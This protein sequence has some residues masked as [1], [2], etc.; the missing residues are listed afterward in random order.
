MATI[1]DSRPSFDHVEFTIEPFVKN[2]LQ[3]K[4]DTDSQLCLPHLQ[5]PPCPRGSLCPLRHANPSPLNFKPVPPIPTTAHGRTVCKHWLRGL[6]KKGNTCEFMHEYNLRKMPECW[7]FAKYGFCSNGDECMYLHVTESMRIRECPSYRKGFCRL[8]PECP[9]KH[10]RKTMCPDYLVGF[11]E[12]GP[13]CP[14]G[15]PKFDPDPDPPSSSTRIPDVSGARFLPEATFRLNRPDWLAF[16]ADTRSGTGGAGGAGGG[17][18]GW[19]DRSGG[20]GGGGG[21]GGQKK[22]LSG[23][24]CYKCAQMGHFANMCP[25]AAVPG[26]RGGVERTGGRFNNRD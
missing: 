26:Q 8:G 25:N 9:L 2:E 6:C 14:L 20:Q 16:A 23:V 18:G 17:G 7:F 3:I 4:L 11:C 12:K 21:G 5:S 24:L 19:V 15:H 22:D 1:I 10:V 13:T